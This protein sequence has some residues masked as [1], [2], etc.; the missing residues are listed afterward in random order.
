MEI[1]YDGQVINLDVGSH[2]IYITCNII[3]VL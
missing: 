3:L 2:S 1:S